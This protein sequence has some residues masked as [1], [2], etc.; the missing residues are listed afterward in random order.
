MVFLGLTDSSFCF[1]SLQGRRV[2]KWVSMMNDYFVLHGSCET[3]FHVWTKTRDH[4]EGKVMEIRRLNRERSGR[5]R[6][7]KGERENLLPKKE[8]MFGSSRLEKMMIF[9][10]ISTLGSFWRRVCYSRRDQEHIIEWSWKRMTER[11]EGGIEWKETMQERERERREGCNKR[12]SSGIISTC[13]QEQ[14]LYWGW[15]GC[16]YKIVQLET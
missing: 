15:K 1:S 8:L 4:C 7:R 5:N 14:E 13:G 2:N 10:P 9:F 11:K 6:V 3:W 16:K 12:T